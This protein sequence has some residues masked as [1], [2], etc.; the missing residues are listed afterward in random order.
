[1]A[2]PNQNQS[3]DNSS[4]IHEIQSVAETIAQLKFLLSSIQFNELL[5]QELRVEG[6]R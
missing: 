4:P 2:I 1:M 3:T 5:V 6:R